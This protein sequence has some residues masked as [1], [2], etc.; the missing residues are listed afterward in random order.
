MENATTAKISRIRTNGKMMALGM[1]SLGMSPVVMQRFTQSTEHYYYYFILQINTGSIFDYFDG[2]RLCGKYK[3][4][5]FRF[6]WRKKTNMYVCVFICSLNSFQVHC[7][8]FQ[9]IHSFIM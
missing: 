5:Y 1:P 9:L 8:K 6:D 7:L 3:L 4:R 2:D